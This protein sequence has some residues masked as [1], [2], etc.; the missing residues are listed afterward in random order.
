MVFTQTPLTEKKIYVYTTMQTIE[1][2]GFVYPSLV[3]VGV[4][5]CGHC[6]RAK[7]LMEQLA[8]RL[9]KSLP[10]IHVDGDAHKEFIT[11]HLGEVRSYPTIMYINT[12][13]QVTRFEDERSFD[14][15]LAFV[16]RE[17]SKVEG[18]LDACDI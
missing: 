18:P 3:F 6:R 9:G 11:Q 7:P 15:L 13:G 10:V 2:R 1:T 4:E 8:T 14:S 16:C 5:W 17:S 12:L